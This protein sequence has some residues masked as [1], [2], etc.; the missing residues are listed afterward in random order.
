MNT[1]TLRSLATLALVLPAAAAAQT[2]SIDFSRYYTVGDSLSAG[3]VSA[4]LVETNQANSVP[5]LIA[6]QARVIDFQQPLITEPGL[7]PQLYLK[8]LVP[9]VVIEPKAATPGLPKNLLLPRPYNNMAVPGATSVDALTRTSGGISDLILR[10]L[11]TQLDQVVRSRPSFVTL[12]IGNNDVLGAAVLG[13]AIDGVTLTPTAVFRQAYGAIVAVLR[14]S[15]ARV[16]AA[17]LPDPTVIP[18]VTTI[19]PYVVDSTGKPV[20]LNGNRIPLL[21]PAGPLPPDAYV[22]LPASA[23]LAKGNGIPK[24]LGG[25]GQPLPDEL[26]LDAGEVSIIRD[27]VSQNNQ[28]VSQICQQAGVPVVDIYG[29]LNGVATSGRIVGGVR[30]TASFLTGGAFSYDGVH[31]TALGYALAANEWIDVINQNGGTLPLVDLAPF[32][33]FPVAAA[34]VEERPTPPFVF[35]REAYESLLALYPP[36][37]QR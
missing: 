34:A 3:V 31:P 9:S 4:S 35:T 26:I 19:K 16:V 10:G 5:A 25:T 13:R 33:G 32:I 37:N 22:L 7:P 20:T 36:L 28:A 23:E 14:A 17:N 11:G 27:H 15:G 29:Y 1:H 8:S 21:G 30:L 6:R 18:Y 12:W 24:E 2:P